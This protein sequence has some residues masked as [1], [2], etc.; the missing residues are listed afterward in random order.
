MI[1]DRGIHVVSAVERKL[2]HVSS[3]SI[4]NEKS[5]ILCVV[6]DVHDPVT[7][8]PGD[9]MAAI[10]PARAYLFCVVRRVGRTH[11]DLAAAI[12]LCRNDCP[13]VRRH[14]NGI[15]VA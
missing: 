12:P 9:S 11:P 10:Q 1:A 2:P 8:G 4:G 7:G 3:V 14:G 6:G 5:P 13:A 15:I